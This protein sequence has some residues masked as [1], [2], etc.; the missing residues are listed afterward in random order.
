MK[1]PLDELESLAIPVQT[2]SSRGGKDAAVTRVTREMVG[3]PSLGCVT[4]V[5]ALLIRW[6]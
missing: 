5:T 4:T 3:T 6:A 1:I 2:E